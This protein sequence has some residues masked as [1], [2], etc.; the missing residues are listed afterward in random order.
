MV[1]LEENYILIEFWAEINLVHEYHLNVD[2]EEYLKDKN[3]YSDLSIWHAFSWK[4]V[5]HFKENN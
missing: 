4:Q 3:D 2:V 1:G 5:H